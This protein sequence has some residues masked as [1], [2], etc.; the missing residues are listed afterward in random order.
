MHRYK[1]LDGFSIVSSGVE[2]QPIH[3]IKTSASEEPSDTSLLT[4]K[5]VVDLVEQVEGEI[6]SGAIMKDLITTEGGMI[7]GGE[8]GEPRELTP[9]ET[10]VEMALMSSSGEVD[11]KQITGIHAYDAEI[12][13]TSGSTLKL[14]GSFGISTEADQKIDT[15]AQNIIT[16]AGN[17]I[18]SSAG[19]QIDRTAPYI[20]DTVTNQYALVTGQGT[21]LR[22]NG[23]QLG[24]YGSTLDI[25]ETVGISQTTSGNFELK[26]LRFSAE[27]YASANQGTKYESDPGHAEIW[28]KNP[29]SSGTVV[30]AN[31]EVLGSCSNSNGN[32]AMVD[33]KSDKV[34][35]EVIDGNGADT[36]VQVTSA[37]VFVHPTSNTGSFSV[38][39]P[40]LDHPPQT[41][42]ITSGG[43]I[44]SGEYF[45]VVANTVREGVVPNIT[46]GTPNGTEML[47]A[48]T[49][50][51]Q[52]SSAGVQ[53][54]GAENQIS[55]TT[56]STTLNA[57]YDSEE[58]HYNSTLDL[59][60]SG[61]T[62]SSHG[63]A[64][65]TNSET[66]SKITVWGDGVIGIEAHN[67]LDLKTYEGDDILIEAG[68]DA[69]TAT[70]R[71]AAEDDDGNIVYSSLSLDGY[72]GASLTTPAGIALT[73][74]S[75]IDLESTS[76]PI[77]IEN[78]G[79][80][81][82][83]LLSKPTN[84]QCEGK[85]LTG[86]YYVELDG[87][88][89][90]T[91]KSTLKLEPNTVTGTVNASGPGA[92]MSL[93]A[94]SVQE[95]GGT[96]ETRT[97]S[98]TLHDTNGIT[99]STSYGPILLSTPGPAA[100]LAG[101]SLYL[102]TTALSPTN[103]NLNGSTSTLTASAKSISLI[104]SVGSNDSGTASFNIGSI[105]GTTTISG[106]S[107]S[108]IGAPNG[109]MDI[110]SGGIRFIA[111]TNVLRVY[112][113]GMEITAG[114]RLTSANSS[115]VIDVEETAP[116]GSDDWNGILA[117]SYDMGALY[118]FGVRKGVVRSAHE[119]DDET[120]P[121]EKAVRE[122]IDA[123]GGGGN[124]PISSAGDMIYGNMWGEAEA[125]PIGDL[126]QVL[127]VNSSG[128][129]EWADASSGGLTNPVEELLVMEKGFQL[130][131][132][133]NTWMDPYDGHVYKTV[134][135]G[136]QTWLAENYQ[137]HYNWAPNN[138]AANVP[139][140]G[141]LYFGNN[142]SG[143]NVP[144]GWHL[145]S[146]DEWNVLINYV[147]NT[148]SLTRAEACAALCNNEEGWSDLT[149]QTN[150]TGMN[151]VAPGS[152]YQGQGVTG[153]NTNG[154]YL[155]S[156]A[157]YADSSFHVC[158]TFYKN[159]IGSHEVKWSGGINQFNQYGASVRLVRDANASDAPQILK[160]VTT[161]KKGATDNTIPTSKA[162]W[163]ECL[164][165]VITS[166]GDLVV[167]NSGGTQVQRLGIGTE[168]QTLMVSSTGMPYWASM[169]LG[170]FTTA[171]RP[172]SPINGSFGFDITIRN[173]VWFIDGVW[174]N[175]AGASV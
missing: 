65:L 171:N 72:S 8:N 138:N 23:G 31:A 119:A 90:E 103:I 142:I 168:G 43:S 161:L 127:T 36:G 88:G 57:Y 45:S 114:A 66:N 144:D 128:L 3:K 9:N 61:A 24:I 69:G 30:V 91:N 126:G 158:M 120:I 123:G 34:V 107:I 131:D 17:H 20:L 122:A 154:Y 157:Y 26:G 169:Y 21:G 29:V 86:A 134:T 85:V 137:G 162:V 16:S 165:N 108:L 125:L 73:A 39:V 22:Y 163:N 117:T 95:T 25:N 97:S 89:N 147:M 102:S 129:P 6:T 82:I 12:E 2:G 132:A 42:T 55:S 135:I 76:G 167:G 1:I 111:P 139:V 41:L 116:S 18:A 64:R 62:L 47:V 109:T 60:R 10:D 113:S 38:S 104:A 133:E 173:V 59:G 58:G 35:L 53:I 106:S 149:W 140:Y 152:F 99:A 44:F 110:T 100:V 145:P 141:G 160:T 84:A 94:K 52:L 48:S 80:S 172:S 15:R 4:E 96:T 7:V 51:V 46:I 83:T 166:G 87:V 68:P 92:S 93:T 14:K 148:Y 115:A 118:R 112:T 28:S 63:F 164:R 67:H 27:A 79:G 13:A 5:G 175:A 71:A 174:V 37:G 170:T 77:D 101:P 124:L 56:G 75:G 40:S 54:T 98:F 121:T 159:Q 156:D 81:N 151:L 70:I 153:F 143:N 150:T 50:I 105:N 130:K 155:T 33:V 136:T 11:W 146:Q 74:E 78:S 49:S 32:Q 19:W